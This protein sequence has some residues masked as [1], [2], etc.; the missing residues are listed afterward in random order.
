MKDSETIRNRFRERRC[1][2][3]I[4]TYNHD[5]T[6][7]QV[8]QGVLGFAPDVIVVN[9]G[10]TDR[11]AEIVKDFRD[12]HVIS[13][14][15]NRGKGFALQCGF[16]EAIKLGFEYAITI[17]SDGQHYP[18]DLL[19]FIDK[20]EEAPGSVIL[21]ARNMKQESVPGPSNFG[22]KF[23]IFWFRVETGIRVPDVQTGFR[24]Y[25]LKELK[26]LRLFTNKYEFEVEVLVRLAWKGVGISWVPVKVYYPPE[27][28]R[29]SHFRKINDFGRVSIINSIL[30]FMAVL[31]IRPFLFIRGLRKKSV[32]GFIQEYFIDSSDSN[33]KLA[34]SVAIGMFVGVTPIWG[35]Q[36]LL[37]FGVAYVFR[38][39]KF[40]TIA[41][42][43]I[44]IPPMIPVLIF[45][46][47][48]CGGLVTGN[49]GPAFSYSNGITMEWV[50]ANFI[51]YLIGSI[52][53]G[54]IL[55]L[56]SGSITYLLLKTFRNKR[57]T[58]IKNTPGQ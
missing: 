55:A 18:E 12:L 14:E 53:L 6:L 21:G 51:Q 41:A 56:T 44:S 24:L 37:A 48:L 25:P 47:Y 33:L 13:Y 4:P 32:K 35:F 30:V 19:K 26:D 3:I 5:A 7:G 22:H 27:T 54:T 43:N 46:S 58:E 45:I 17:D 8:I 16:Q 34:L 49:S 23:S 29:V 42:S 9:D 15:K 38:L 39:N 2:V 31:W 50:K 11:T 40:V 28:E 36:M 52:I 57:P 1:C 10:S 20:I